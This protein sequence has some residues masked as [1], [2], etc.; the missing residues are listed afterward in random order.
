[1]K[2]RFLGGWPYPCIYIIYIYIYM[3]DILRIAYCI[4]HIAYIYIHT[5]IHLHI[6]L[7]FTYI[8]YIFVYLFVWRTNIDRCSAPPKGHPWQFLSDLV[9]SGKRFARQKWKTLIHGTK[10]PWYHGT[11]RDVDISNNVNVKN[12]YYTLLTSIFI[13][14][15]NMSKQKIKKKYTAV[16]LLGTDFW[17]SGAAS[18][19]AR[20]NRSLGPDLTA[21]EP[22]EDSLAPS[23]A[24]SKLLN[25]AE[26]QHG[27]TVFTSV[28]ITE[29]LSREF[30]K[31]STA[32]FFGSCFWKLFK[33][34]FT[35]ELWSVFWECSTLREVEAKN[36]GGVHSGNE[37]GRK[38]E[39]SSQEERGFWRKKT[40]FNFTLE[41]GDGN[42]NKEWE[43]LDLDVYVYIY[44]S[45][46]YI[47][48]QYIYIYTYS[49][50]YI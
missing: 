44:I 21:E 18:L 48:I 35:V 33:E 43:M 36:H 8:T 41:N 14:F 30:K 22:L 38:Q 4:L 26:A 17:G 42:T 2:G 32:L 40:G 15:S 9:R 11:D 12:W 5:Q 27:T 46:F 50:T 34:T 28:N 39:R 37:K 6:Q 31:P 16:Q 25:V 23:P 49:Y 13:G 20:V 19:C 10:P 47:Y 45:T 3:Y 24:G 1:M 7:R 29:Y